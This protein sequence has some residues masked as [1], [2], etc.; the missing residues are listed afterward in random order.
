MSGAQ[1]SRTAASDM[2]ER[3]YPTGGRASSRR[4]PYR[5][6]LA[7]RRL[8]EEKDD[9]AAECRDGGDPRDRSREVSRSVDEAAE[10]EESRRGSED[11]QDGEQ[12][13]RGTARVRR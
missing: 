11:V 1:G 2:P 12:A 8:G 13:G 9:Q 10:G 4:S 7:V 3:A 6:E 5:F